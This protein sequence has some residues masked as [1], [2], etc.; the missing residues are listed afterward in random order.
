MPLLREQGEDVE[1]EG[2]VCLV[3]I[4]ETEVS[5]LFPFD[6]IVD[7]SCININMKHNL[8]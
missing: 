5:A 1:V 3:V 2:E 6:L 4:C 8:L 7:S